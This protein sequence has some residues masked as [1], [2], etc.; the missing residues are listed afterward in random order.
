MEVL[1]E[2]S[3]SCGPRGTRGS[4][5]ESSNPLERERIEGGWWR[6]LEA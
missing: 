3:E 5:V 1:L 2:S 6:M 4:D